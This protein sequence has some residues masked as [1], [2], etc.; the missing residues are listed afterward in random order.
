MFF[1]LQQPSWSPST[2]PLYAC[3]ADRKGQL[4]RKTGRSVTR[5]DTH[6]KVHRA[7][8]NYKLPTSNQADQ[9][10]H[11]QR[12][13]SCTVT[14]MKTSLSGSV[15]RYAAFA[16]L[17]VGTVVVGFPVWLIRGTSHPPD[18]LGQCLFLAIGVV[19]GGPLVGYGITL[20]W[21]TN[22]HR[23]Y[24]LLAAGVNY[25]AIVAILGWATSDILFLALGV[26]ALS[27]SYRYWHL[28]K[29]PSHH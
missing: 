18:L 29:E 22:K 14:G 1:S 27:G 8:P 26:A 4:A 19:L 17:S 6:P 7:K 24:V 15:H 25:I 21:G 10:T 20:L 9:H 12:P 13:I 11:P 3:V 16:L 23:S 2:I 5:R 28:A